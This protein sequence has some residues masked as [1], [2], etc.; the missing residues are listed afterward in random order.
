MS[1]QPTKTSIEG[2]KIITITPLLRRLWPSPPNADPPV[3]AS[4]IAGAV[5]HIF[6]NSLSAVQTGAL[7]TALHFTGEDRK[8]D[9]IALCAG[10]MRNAAASIDT[11]AL[12]RA[13]KERGAHKAEGEY[14]GGLVCLLNDALG[15]LI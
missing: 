3:T 2:P 12:T 8:A 15:N 10:A 1:S 4:E 9:V 7:L 6:T 5:S 14:H 13:V 11:E